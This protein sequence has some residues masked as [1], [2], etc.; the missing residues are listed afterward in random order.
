M[1][2]IGAPELLVAVVASP[3]GSLTPGI[4]KG[5]ETQ[6]P[7]SSA[8]VG[9][10]LGLH[11]ISASADRP[12]GPLALPPAA[13][14]MPPESAHVDIDREAG[15]AALTDRQTLVTAAV[16]AAQPTVRTAWLTG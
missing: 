13:I 10:L 4:P 12:C 5:T 16:R 2:P 15:A 3:A 9:I 11:V 1:T 6:V 14:E 7:V 8:A